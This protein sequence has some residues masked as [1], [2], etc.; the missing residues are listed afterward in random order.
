MKKS[1]LLI[2]IMLALSGILFSQNVGINDDG[3]S[4]DA[5]AILDV[6]STSKGLLIPRMTLTQRNSIINPAKGLFIYQTDGA[7]GIYTNIGT[8]SSPDW[9]LLA[10]NPVTDISDSDADTKIQVE[11]SYDEDKIR[12]DVGGTERVVINGSGNIGVGEDDPMEKIDANGNIKANAFYD[13]DDP[14]YYMNLNSSGNALLVNGN[15]GIGT[16]SPSEKLDVDGNINLYSYLYFDK[17]NHYTKMYRDGYNLNLSAPNGNVNIN[18]PAFSVDGETS[19]VGIGTTSPIK[20]FHV[21]GEALFNG[22]TLFSEYIKHYS[23]ENTYIRFINDEIIINADGVASGQSMSI[24]K[25]INTWIGLYPTTHLKGNI[26]YASQAW[27]SVHSDYFYAGSTSH[28]YSYSDKRIKTD[29]HPISN[30]SSKV[31]RLNPVTYRLK[32]DF[33]DDQGNQF[34]LIAQ[35]AKEV[36]PEIVHYNKDN[37]LYS[38]SYVALI[39]VLVKAF[40]EQQLQIEELQRQIEILQSKDN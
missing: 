33:S 3:S 31:L 34:G 26:G 4:P 10:V 24:K 32:K 40:Q 37:D 7:E 17:D 5:S 8:P 14:T 13:K 18:S 35:E 1:G 38:I 28:Y 29:I 23:D 16:T 11:E 12:I 20:L 30:A 36:I 6:K 15:V 19:R 21:Q 9:R 25:G 22:V 27:Y 2:L 39:P